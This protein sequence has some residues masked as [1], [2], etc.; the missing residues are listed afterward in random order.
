[1]EESHKPPERIAPDG[2]LLSEKHALHLQKCRYRCS[3]C[4]ENFCLDCKTMPYHTGKTCE[5]H[6]ESLAKVRCKYCNTVLPW[7]GSSQEAVCTS[8]DCIRRKNKACGKRLTCGH[9]CDGIARE[10][11][12]LPCL[13]CNDK[14]AEFCNLC[15][16]EDLR[17][18]PCVQLRCGHIF[19]WHCISKR[20]E[21]R[22][23]SSKI[24]FTFAKCALC[25]AMVEHPSFDST[26]NK[27]IK[28]KTRVEE[29]ALERL[30]YEGLSKGDQATDL[31]LANSRYQFYLCHRCQRPYFGGIA[32]CLAQEG[33]EENQFKREDLICGSCS[34]SKLGNGRKTCK[35]HGDQYVEYKCRF[36]CSIATFFCF[37][38]THFCESCHKGWTEGSNQRPQ[39]LVK[40][41][42]CSEK[43]AKNCST[44]A[45]EHCFGCSLC[46]IKS[47]ESK[48]LR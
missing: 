3:S 1:M 13:T 45:G 37:G 27:I 11:R 4:R 21:L 22:W 18:A 12:C 17:A 5:E 6:K 44:A 43:H 19:H 25:S 32:D 14:G 15:W 2:Q 30:K 16:I 40:P 10:K 34:A 26:M 46:R 28:L 8:E 39:S 33:G 36:C 41:C 38:S 20:L 9:N 24:S 48:P 23:T 42:T 47:H 31:Q 35:Q 7:R 29:A